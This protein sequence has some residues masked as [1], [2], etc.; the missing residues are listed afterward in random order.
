MNSPPVEDAIERNGRIV[1]LV[2]VVVGFALRARGLS[3]YWLNADEGIYYSTLTWSS[4]GAFWSEVLAN[5]HP[6]GFYLLL[7]TL[8]YVTWDFVWLRAASAIFGAAAI[9]IFWLVGRELG[10]GG[11]RGVA[12]GLATATL[13]ALNPNAIVLSQ[14]IRPYA[15]LVLLLS[16]ALLCLLRYRA[17]P[18][19]TTLVAYSLISTLGVAS[20]YSAALALA[21]F[22]ALIGVDLLGRRFKGREASEL[23]A[24]HA[25]PCL[26]FAGLYLL[27]GRG[28]LGSDLMQ[29]AIRP[30]GWLSGWLVDSPLHAWHNFVAYQDFNLPS[31]FRASAAILWLIA[32]GWAFTV[33]EPAIAVLSSVAIGVAVG[34]SALEVY[35][36][37]EG[38]HNAWLSVFT[39][40]ALGWLLGRLATATRPQAWMGAAMLVGLLGGAG[41][42]ERL[43]GPPD[44]PSTA[45]ES[46]ATGDRTVDRSETA[47]LEE[48]LIRRADIAPLIL[49]TLDPEE[50]PPVILMTEQTFNVLMPLYPREKGGLVFSQDSTFMHFPYGDR[51]IVVARTWDW[52]SVADLVSR[53]GRVAAHLPEGRWDGVSPVVVL[54]GGW[55]SEILP[56]FTRF[57]QDEVASHIFVAPGF[58][59][60]G[61]VLV[62][63]A[64]AVIDP[65]ALSA[66]R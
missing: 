4:F 46:S 59:P 42:L 26:V 62:R 34:A 20:H 45:V 30:G 1:A 54:A 27:H 18:E 49:E 29:S 7:R 11:R 32:I 50:G 31:S 43:V 61:T 12:T 39:I 63:L 55:G 40:P 38:R 53:L 23:I 57:A 9:W 37:G 41:P 58:D 5:A 35:P 66:L 51:E 52:A 33:R 3:E 48:R 13:V 15:L 2:L 16:T 25:V 19:R 8:G 60:D 28:A 65:V 64:S 10:G 17:K 21:A 24:A 14:V 44:R 47:P 6:P 56:M 36:F 22:S